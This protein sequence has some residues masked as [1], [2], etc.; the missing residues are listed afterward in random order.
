MSAYPDGRACVIDEHLQIHHISCDV[1]ENSI[2][3][4]G[5][6]DKGT[7]YATQTPTTTMIHT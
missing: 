6:I 3:Q 4:E 7:E 1:F 5:T 2:D